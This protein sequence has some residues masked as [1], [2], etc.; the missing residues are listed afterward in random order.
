MPTCIFRW[1]IYPFY[2]DTPD[3]PSPPPP[4]PPDI[5]FFEGGKRS[6]SQWIVIG[7]VVSAILVIVL[8]GFFFWRIWRR[9]NEEEARRRAIQLLFSE[10][11][12][13]HNILGGEKQVESPDFPL[14]PLGQI[15]EATQDFSNEYKL[16]EG[17][18]GPVY[19]EIAVKRL[20]RRSGQG[21]KEFKNE[22]IL[23][24]K[25]QHKNLV[26]LLGC[27]L[28]GKE[29]LL[30]YEYMPNKS[31][32]MHLFDST[33]SVQ[34]DWKRRVAI[35]NGIARGL[36]YLHEDSRLKIIHRDLKTSNI[37]LDHEMNPKISD[38][39]MARIFGGNQSEA[40]T[41]RVVGT[42]GYMAPEYAM[43]GIFSVKS[44]VFSFRVLLLEIISGRKNTSFH[45][46]ET[47]RSLLAYAWK[48]WCEG[49]A[50]ELMDLVLA[51]AHVPVEVMKFI[52]I[53]LLCVQEDPTYRPTMSS[54]VFTLVSDNVTLPKP[55]QPAFSIVRVA[56]SIQ[57]SLNGKSCSVNE[58]TFSSM[59][60]R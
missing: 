46:S 18:F 44:D 56:Q 25:L 43:D 42:Y 48:L 16:G 49:N 32:D 37:L 19:K 20:S 9:K 27:C 8:F 2:D 31:L 10:D 7:A 17:G 3:P 13:E 5:C 22:V 53:G 57:S 39:G 30:I 50:L 47:G 55:S 60:P 26:R 41:L 38:F 33:R 28:E 36:L 52:H 1:E 35:I 23:I 12:S 59:T 58:V 15:L 29:L 4:I 34:L 21:L 54:V 45:L 24:A 14:F 40:N 11:D 51:Q 6:Q